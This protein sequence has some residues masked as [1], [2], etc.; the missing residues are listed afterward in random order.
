MESSPSKD[1]EWSQD[2]PF[3]LTGQAWPILS[4]RRCFSAVDYT[5]SSR[6]LPR[7]GQAARNR[8]KGFPASVEQA[9]G[10]GKIQPLSAQDTPELLQEQP[11]FFSGDSEGPGAT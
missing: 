5:T 11:A 7:S 3:W 1:A 8:A 10:G 6:Q 9:E 4:S 2:L